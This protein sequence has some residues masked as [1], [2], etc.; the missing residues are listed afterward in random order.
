MADKKIFFVTLFFLGIGTGILAQTGRIKGN[1]LDADTKEALIGASVAIQ[2][3]TLGAATDLNGDYKILNVPPGTYTLEASYISYQPVTKQQIVVEKGKETIVEFHL[4]AKGISLK[5][6]E[7]V[8]KAN[9]ESEN[10]LL[11]EQKKSLLVTQTVGAKELS[12]K[13]L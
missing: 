10:V 12:R 9:R 5:E 11:L 6:V 1:V 3:T 7:V 8:A 13:D 2:G 4:Q